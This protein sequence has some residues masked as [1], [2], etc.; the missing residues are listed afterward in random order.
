M[1]ALWAF[2]IIAGIIMLLPGIVA[3]YF[4]VR[5]GKRGEETR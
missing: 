1:V 4:Y 3:T 2:L 5:L